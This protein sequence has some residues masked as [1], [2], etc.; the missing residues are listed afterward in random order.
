VVDQMAG[1]SD[2]AE[3]MPTGPEP[4]HEGPDL[5][6]LINPE[7]DPEGLLPNIEPIQLLDH[8]GTFHE[9]P[10]YQ[11]DLT[12]EQLRELHRYMVIAR[13]V[14]REA[15]NLQRQGQLGVY[16]SCR[17]QEGAQVGSAYALRDEDWIFPS[18]R[19][20]AAG[21]TRGIDTAASSR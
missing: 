21:I 19:E 9:H 15:I 20:L 14:D 10:D 6:S 2:Q 8:T 5:R 18:Y 1:R 13:K 3:G 4:E 12:D 7:V 11:L 17:G 16:A